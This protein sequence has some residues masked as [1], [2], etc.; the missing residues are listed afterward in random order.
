MRFNGFR[1][2]LIP[3]IFSNNLP[4]KLQRR[5]SM[6]DIKVG[7]IVEARYNSGTYIGEVLED[8]R[9]F[10]LVKVLAV[11]VHPT[12]GDLH[13]RGQVEGVAFHERKALAFQEKMNETRRNKQLFTGEIQENIDSIKRSVVEM[14][15]KLQQENTPFNKLSLQK[16]AD[17]EEHFY[18]K[19]YEEAKK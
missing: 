19:L 12:Q 5:I 9:N 7:D 15:E 13:N 17:L 16:I 1:H 2:I 14:K 4:Y 6:S 18:F 3:I 11:L 10:F 8:R